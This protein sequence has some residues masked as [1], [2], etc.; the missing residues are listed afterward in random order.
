MRKQVL[1]AAPVAALL[2]VLTACTPPGTLEPETS[3]SGAVS[4]SPEPSVGDV[5][6]PDPAAPSIPSWSTEDRPYKMLD[7]TYVLVSPK[8]PFPENVRADIEKRLADIEPVLSGADTEKTDETWDAFSRLAQQLRDETGRAVIIFTNT[9]VPAT[10]LPR[11]V[12]FGGT[13]RENIPAFQDIPGGEMPFDE[14]E[15]RVFEKSNQDFF[16]VFYR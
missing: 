13:L 16:D 4:A 15:K 9:T 11:W 1:L 10:G 14:Y 3:P 5:V 8:K 2:L 12:H 7:G 6:T